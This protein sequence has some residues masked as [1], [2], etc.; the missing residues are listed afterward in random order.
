MNKEAQ[1]GGVPGPT[2]NPVR[3]ANPGGGGKNHKNPGQP[4]N[5]PKAA[6]PDSPE[7][8]TV[9]QLQNAILE[10]K[11]SLE[12]LDI[13]SKEN[14][15]EQFSKQNRMD[16]SKLKQ[17]ESY[18]PVGH[19]EYF[20]DSLQ[21]NIPFTDVGR[22]SP[23]FQTDKER[24]GGTNPLGNFLINNYIGKNVKS[25]ADT[26]VPEKDRLKQSI[27]PYDFR[28][29][30]ETIGHVGTPKPERPQNFQER[31][32]Q[33][34][35]NKIIEKYDP[36]TNTKVKQALQEVDQLTKKYEDQKKEIL[37]SEHTDDNQKKG[38]LDLLSKDYFKAQNEIYK[39]YNLNNPTLQRLQNQL[40]TL[41]T[42][43]DS[44]YEKKN[45]GLGEEKVDGIYH[46]RTAN[47]LNAI[48]AITRG[49]L[50]F[51]KDMGK[52]APEL[53]KD[54][55]QYNSLIN[56]FNQ[57]VKNI[58]ANTTDINTKI[59]G[60][61]E[62]TKNINK[63]ASYISNEFIIQSD[64]VKTYI[65]QE[66]SFMAFNKFNEKS[67]KEAEQ[68]DKMYED[69]LIDN[70]LKPNNLKP[71]I[72][73]YKTTF[74]EGTAGIKVNFKNKELPLSYESLWTTSNLANAYKNAFGK[75]P[76]KE[77][78]TELVNLVEQSL[79][80]Q[81]NMRHYQQQVDQGY[82]QPQAPQEKRRTPWDALSNA[83]LPRR[84]N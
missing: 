42:K 20:N 27:T 22:K 48:S 15:G 43:L 14:P 31:A 62:I 60:L 1:S 80:Y 78:L 39:K 16:E 46:I 75:N 4:T 82:R 79:T 29:L 72:D 19:K 17:N 34:Q 66:H 38:Q 69:K 58:K 65:T 83:K 41:K 23:N 44:E 84:L 55:A 45:P 13:A 5:K 61:Q 51:A 8:A 12:Q 11:T 73:S 25:L 64:D 53:S 6:K 71:Y 50:D 57:V 10:Y 40:S 2:R 56:I 33:N 24:L 81:S 67:V 36:K 9:R 21:Q 59:K 26:D 68:T 77:E 37:K 49:L 70:T 3:K 35:I 28:A 74:Q 54:L 30:V 32:L 63:Q 7:K 52:E 47:A 76:T 18:A